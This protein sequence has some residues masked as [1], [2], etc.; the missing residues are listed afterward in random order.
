VVGSVVLIGLGLAMVIAP[1]YVILTM[2]ALSLA[3]MAGVDRRR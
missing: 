3:T 1:A 2:A